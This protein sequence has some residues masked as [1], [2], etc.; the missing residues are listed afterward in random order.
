MSDFVQ[1]LR[2]AVRMMIRNPG[3]TLAAILTPGLGIGANTAIFSVVNGVLLRPLPLPRPERLMTAWMERYDGKGGENPFSE[4]DY[5]DWKEQSRSFAHL[6]A[7]TDTT[8]VLTGQ[9]SPQ[10]LHVAAVTRE[11]FD[12]L[13]VPPL[14]GRS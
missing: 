5:L 6:A 8:S 9:G 12:A 4:A 11:F 3:F 13:E 7:F 1:D 14:L 2:Y 10:R